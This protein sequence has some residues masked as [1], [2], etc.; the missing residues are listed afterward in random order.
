MSRVA[1]SFGIR[2]GPTGLGAGPPSGG[3]RDTSRLRL[4]ILAVVV[5]SLFATM[6]ARLWY[7][8]VMVAPDLRVEAQ[9]NS[10]RLVA[11]EAPRGR[12]LDRNGKVLVDNRIVPTVTGDREVVADHPEVLDKLAAYL[13]N[14]TRAD[15]QR[16]LEDV[17]FSQFKPAPL[18]ED[19]GKEKVVYLREHQAEFP[20]IDVT[21]VAQRHYPHG[22]LAAHILGYVG[23]INDK[24]LVPRRAAGY[25]EGDSIGKS[26]T[27][28]A[29]ESD[30]R[31]T[32]EVE[33]LL[34]DS[35]GRVL[36]SLGKQPAVPGHD[37]Q[38]TVDLDIQQL[39]EESLRQA[40]DQ[41]HGAWDNRQLKYFIAPGG[42]VVVEDPRDGAIVAMASYPTYDP[43]V[44]VN[45]ISTA[46]FSALQDPANNFPLN[47]RAIQGEYAPGST[48]KLV[49][50]LAGLGRDV[51]G[52]GTTVRDTGSVQ[53]GPQIFRN[54]LSVAHGNVDL[55]RAL[56]VSSDV[57]FYLLG[58][59]LNTSKR[60]YPI[61]EM[62]RTMGYG[63]TTGIELPFELEGR[64]PDPESK[65]RLHESNPE[66]FPYG[67]W[68]TG[69]NV[70]LS[71]GQGD[72]V[73]TPLQL[74][75]AYATF[76]NGGTVW[77][78][79]VGGSIVDVVA[80]T[81]TPVAPRSTAKVE[82][83]PG[84]RDA[85]MAGLERVVTTEEGTA[86]PAF[87]GF[88]LSTFRVAGKTGT[89]EVN[90]K[91]DT[92]LFVGLGPVEDPRYV[93]TAV[94]EE[95]GFGSAAAAP[96]VRR[97]FDGIVGIAPRS[98]SRTAARD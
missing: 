64:V 83:P 73:V 77:A 5:M 92:A 30:L 76:A 97:V 80:Q 20:G 58:E 31:G 45:G 2:P 51:I 46:L 12:I 90:T 38:L 53:V 72:L 49:T 7:L 24:E 65:Q 82:L 43:A 67:D 22:S 94:L 44:F 17:R 1:Q 13:G 93:V 62:A 9:D 52:P 85:I 48:F 63:T 37:V 15:L 60:P 19:I 75:N 57:Y 18:A 98:V 55:S 34:V 69:D 87:V 33:K 78:P 47:N 27:E 14:V 21:Q 29:Y 28:L 84:S 59:K 6:L 8:Q 96:V 32:P 54:A 50:A 86:Y 88:P 35:Q 16:R 11:T 70:N 89:A 61:P 39:A 3:G 10:V 68:F 25:R 42:A 40:I 56:A 23:E 71:V 66:A 36:R 91:Q 41:A 95:A 26:G 79:H 81:S 4:G 74:A